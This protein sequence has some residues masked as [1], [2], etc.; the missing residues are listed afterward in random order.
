MLVKVKEVAIDYGEDVGQVILQ[1]SKKDLNTFN[2]LKDLECDLTIDKHR[3]NRGLKAN[4]YLWILC[5]KIADVIDSTKEEVYRDM[6]K[7][8]GIFK[9]MTMDNSAVPTFIK[10]WTDKGMGWLVE[11][12]EKE[13]NMTTLIVYYGTSCYNSRQFAKVLD[14]LIEEAKRLGIETLTPNQIE[15]MKA[16]WKGVI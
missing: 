13:N 4:A 15:E 8:K 11:E 12:L 10:L 2:K 16:S 6:I 1:T 14:Y 9:T 7:S 3:E 5:Q